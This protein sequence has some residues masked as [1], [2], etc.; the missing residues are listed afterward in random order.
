MPANAQSKN[1]PIHTLSDRRYDGSTVRFRATGLFEKHYLEQR[2]DKTTE[3]ENK[4]IFRHWVQNGDVGSEGF[5]KC[6]R[7]IQALWDKFKDSLDSFNESELEDKWVR[8]IFKILGWE[9]DTQSSFTR[10]GRQHK[11]DYI[12]FPSW[13][14]L[15]TVKDKQGEKSYFDASL[16]VADAKAWGVPL[17]GGKGTS[18]HPSSQIVR[19][20]ETSRVPWGILT[21]GRYWR[22]YS[23]LVDS[24]HRVY[25]ETDLEICFS[26]PNLEAFR[27]F[28]NFFRK[29]AFLQDS[30]GK[31]FLIHV[32]N[33][34]EQAAHSI[35]NDLKE[36]SFIVVEDICR[37]FLGS[38]MNLDQESRK[39][40][41]NHS[42]YL[43][44]RMMFVLNCEA[45]GI[46]D[47]ND[48]TGYG[49]YSLRNL[50]AKLNEEFAIGHR[51]SNAS[52]TY[53]TVLETFSILEKGD[54][55]IGV[56]GFGEFL[57]DA[58]DKTFFQKNSAPDWAMNDAL[59][60]LATS[61]DDE[62]NRKFIDF[63]TLAPDHLGALFE[64]LLENQLAYADKDYAVVKGKLK[65]WSSLSS[66]QKRKFESVKISEG[67]P[68]LV[69]PESNER[70][71]SGSYYTPDYIVNHIVEKTLEPICNG[72]TVD[73]LLTLKVADPAMG[74]GHFLLGAFKYLED[75]ILGALSEKDEVDFSK[76]RNSIL[77]N[78]L[79]GVDLN[80]IAVELSK[81]SLWIYTATR[82]Q[83][84]EDLADQF[85]C[86]NALTSDPK[87]HASFSWDNEFF[88]PKKFRKFDA[89]VGNPPYIRVQGRDEEN[90]FA[91]YKSATGSYDTYCLFIERGI[92]LLNSS[93][94]LGY[95]VPHRFMKTDYGQ[96]IRTFLAE[97]NCVTSILDF[98]G[99]MVFED[100]SINTCIL[101]CDRAR[102]DQNVQVEQIVGHKYT[103]EEMNLL[104]KRSS[105][106]TLCR[107]GKVNSQF[108]SKENWIFILENESALW[109]KL[110]SSSCRLRD[111]TDAIFQG[112]KTSADDIYIVEKLEEKKGLYKVY[113]KE[114]ES[115]HWIEQEIAHPLVKGGETKRFQI[116]ETTKLIIFPYIRDGKKSR[117]LVE[118]ELKKKFPLA[119]KYLLQNKKYLEN[120][121][122]GKMK[123]DKWF[124]Y[125]YPK[126][127]DLMPLPKVITPDYYERASFGQDLTGKYFF[128]GGGAGGYGIVPLD[129]VSPYYLMGILNSKAA[130]WYLRKISVRS[131]STAYS[132]V[133]KFISEIPMVSPLECSKRQ[134][135]IIGEIEKL[136][137]KIETEKAKEKV[138][139]LT[140]LEQK[141]DSLV[142]DLY[143]LNKEDRVVIEAAFVDSDIVLREVKKLAS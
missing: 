115:E 61:V 73:E 128:C 55:K 125:I 7:E 110:N 74:S 111:L 47:T 11:P 132:Y 122:K 3:S 2:I 41:Y 53:R 139:S 135:E 124:G 106:G 29:E 92:S 38:R 77:K 95:I 118:D 9:Y 138:S 108:L 71:S 6:F 31:S 45:K 1:L 85:K 37:G 72:K 36:K 49:P 14:A 35:Q 120:R 130:D 54:K 8:P 119:H 141:L 64:G 76:I 65:E 51:G 32:L 84:L 99:Y 137:K 4:S 58:G 143:G 102:K 97:E 18:E 103:D 33:Q 117:L 19:Y 46:L 109:R 81:F 105:K 104:L 23:S 114:T 100:A 78:C 10:R 75:K 121:E 140:E 133:K 21:D 89:I 107:T 13:D 24:G 50:V 48:R 30:S 90:G 63:E 93:G 5:D 126:A 94:R 86:G 66:E 88:G 27:Y 116:K 17:D 40:V 39:E 123:N 43:L 129:G 79:F 26:E 136:S 52:K 70:K 28:Y 12:M 83:E 20:M 56:H 96:G 15:K 25:F 59:L 16:A 34:G 44:F 98:D 113:S 80:P 87:V 82:G 131:Y 60:N 69:S 42:L 22:L 91:G 112:L 134:G 62:G 57:F 142:Y 127:L 67:Q 68:L 101:I